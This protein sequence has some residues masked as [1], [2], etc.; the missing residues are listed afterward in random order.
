V[1]EREARRG[2]QSE[3]TRDVTKTRFGLLSTASINGAILGARSDDAPFTVDAVSS[4]DP[5]RAEAYARREGI[6]RAHGSYDQL[7]A[8]DAID[9]VYIALPN[10]LHHEWTMRALAAGKHVLVEKPYTRLPDEVEAAHDAADRRGL[11]LAEAHMWRHSGQ[12]RLLRELLPRVGTVQAVHAAFFGI[13]PGAHDVRFVAALGGGA[14]LDLGCYC[15]SAC[16][17]V[18]GEPDRVYGEEWAGR[19]GVDERFAATLRFG[20]AAATF[21]CGFTA[22]TNRIE[23]VGD[24]GVLLVPQAFVD[25]PGLVVCNGEEHRVDAGN[26]YRLQLDDFCAAVRGERAPLIGRTEMLG[27]ARVLDALLRSPAAGRPV[28]L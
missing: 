28:E 23:V 20:D 15:V 27:Q 11:V 16:R 25:P 19:G 3:N 17:L 12:T 24:T 21:H 10:A 8:D 6:P 18:L 5:V 26:H 22:R 4:R 13:L 7:L 14:L 2:S 9:A 1:R